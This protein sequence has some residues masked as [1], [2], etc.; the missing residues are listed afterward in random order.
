MPTLHFG[1]SLGWAAFASVSALA[2]FYAAARARNGLAALRARQQE[3]ESTVLGLRREIAGVAR[4]LA[5]GVERQQ[6]LERQAA[7]LSERIAGIAARAESPTLDRAIASARRGA[8]PGKLAAEF[9][10]S[11]GEADLVARLHGRRKRA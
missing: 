6:R 2:V 7:L 9:G 3:L 4:G 5:R 8:E 11:R 10:L 1:P